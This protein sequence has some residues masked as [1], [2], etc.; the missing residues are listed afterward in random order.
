MA[1]GRIAI[2]VLVHSGGAR[3][4]SDRS[5]AADRWLAEPKRLEICSCGRS[6]PFGTAGTGPSVVA[7]TLWPTGC[8]GVDCN[9]RGVDDA[10]GWI[11]LGDRL[12]FDGGDHD[13]NGGHLWPPLSPAF[14]IVRTFGMNATN[15][16]MQNAPKKAPVNRN[17]KRALTAIAE[18]VS[19]VL[20]ASALT[21]WGALNLVVSIRNASAAAA[22]DTP[23]E[24]GWIT[25]GFVALTAVLPFLIGL[26]MFRKLYSQTKVR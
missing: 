6:E 1:V 15:D 20:A 3:S 5:A 12:F 26:N 21:M 9:P 18:Y 4:V 25:L 23:A 19:R 22:E 24:S 10:N 14:E 7:E 11:V 13:W 8:G 17:A 2:F 16:S